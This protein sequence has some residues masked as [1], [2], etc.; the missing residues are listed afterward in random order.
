MSNFDIKPSFIFILILLL[1]I[2]IIKSLLTKENFVITGQEK[3]VCDTGSLDSCDIC[4]TAYDNY[5]L[6]PSI[7]PFVVK[8]ND[9]NTNYQN[10]INDSETLKSLGTRN[11]PVFNNIV[12]DYNPNDESSTKI[13]FTE[14]L[15]KAPLKTACCF[16]AKDNNSQTSVLARV[17]L[18]PNED[19][20]PLFKNFDFKLKSLNIPENACP[21]DY[22]GGSTNCNAFFDV[23]CKNVVNEFNK[24]NLT[25]DKFIYYAPECACYAPKTKIQEIYPE[26]T[27]PACYKT[28]CD[29]IIDPIA[30]VDPISRNNPCD[31]TVCN[32]VFNASNIKAGGNITIDAKLENICGNKMP[33]EDTKNTNQI[34]TEN[35]NDHVVP[36]TETDTN[37]Q[38]IIPSTET[39]IIIPSIDTNNTSIIWVIIIFIIMLIC[40]SSMVIYINL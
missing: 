10:N 16:R 40:T 28:N 14:L 30:Y 25:A 6:Y 15:T 22:Y 21:V 39:D 17:P 18:N 13:A 35:N 34:D 36:S 32:N 33:S 27:P 1:I 12:A 37:N 23:Y 5:N 2:F 31:I 4:K 29:N 26:N 38:I 8:G 3:V 20:D 7:N 19:V 9:I 11:Y 24:L